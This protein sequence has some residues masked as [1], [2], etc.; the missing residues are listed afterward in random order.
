MKR[1][2]KDRI[3]KAYFHCHFFLQ[4]QGNLLNRKRLS[5]SNVQ[6]NVTI[7]HKQPSAIVGPSKFRLLHGSVLKIG[8]LLH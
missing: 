6:I 5:R 2:G 1:F 3:K 8:I 4:M 7:K